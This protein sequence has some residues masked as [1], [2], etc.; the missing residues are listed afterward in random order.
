VV[1]ASQAAVRHLPQ[2]GRI[3]SIGSC[4][5]ERVATPGISLYAL[6]KSALIG[7]T[8]GLARDLGPRGITVNVVHPGPPTPT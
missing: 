2:G 3:I 4:L 7:W 6:S 8:K 5:A 1:I